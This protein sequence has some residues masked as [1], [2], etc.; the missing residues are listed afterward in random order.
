MANAERAASSVAKQSRD[1]Y[2]NHKDDDRRGA[3]PEPSKGD[4][5]F[6]LQPRNGRTLPTSNWHPVTIELMILVVATLASAQMSEIMDEL[7]SRN[8]LDHLE[9]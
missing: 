4:Q 1:P 6:I 5:S 2:H 9:T 3:R 7:D 8:P